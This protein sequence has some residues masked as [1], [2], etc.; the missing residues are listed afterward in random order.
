MLVLFHHFKFQNMHL[1]YKLEDEYL[2]LVSFIASPIVMNKVGR[3]SMCNVRDSQSVLKVS[4][5]VFTISTFQSFLSL[6]VWKSYKS[7]FQ[8]STFRPRLE[9]RLIRII[10]YTYL[11]M[12]SFRLNASSKT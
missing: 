10:D 1:W 12:Q 2:Q 8:I 9:R 6:H 4:N 3:D 11:L 7:N 5:Y